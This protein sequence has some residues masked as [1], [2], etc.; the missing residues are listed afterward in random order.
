MLSRPDV[1][2]CSRQPFA[3]NQIPASRISTASQSVLALYPNPNLPGVANNFLYLPT[4]A[5]YNHEYLAR[6]DVT[7]TSRNTAFIRFNTDNPYQL[8]PSALP[9]S[10]RDFVGGSECR[11][12]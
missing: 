4:A 8:S 12:Q 6:T 2:V 7:L 10:G 3:G 1:L 9:T 11:G 5:N